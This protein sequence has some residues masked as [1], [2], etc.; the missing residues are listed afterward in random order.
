MNDKAEPI[1]I[2]KFGAVYGIKGWLKIHSYTEDSEGIFKYKPLLMK[3]KGQF[4]PVN[5]ADWK[6]HNNGFVGKIVGFDVR[7]DAQALVGLE[8][9]IDPSKLP[10]LEEDFYWRDLVGCQVNTDNGY[11]RCGHRYDGN[12]LK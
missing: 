2:G 7:E 3:S 5:I 12:R 8:L 9:F 6:R 11:S 10:E 4:Q 1:V